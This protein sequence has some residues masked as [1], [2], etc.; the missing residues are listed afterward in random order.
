[1][2]STFLYEDNADLEAICI[3]FIGLEANQPSLTS[4][5]NNYL[6]ISIPQGTTV[7]VYRRPF[8]LRHL[9][10]SLQ[11]YVMPIPYF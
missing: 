7:D 1:M 2:L 8:Q 11:L 3:V 6:D 4:Q 5:S 10:S 9:H